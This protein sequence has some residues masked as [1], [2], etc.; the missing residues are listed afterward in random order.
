MAT[1][2]RIDLLG[3][4]RVQCGERGVTRFPTQKTGGLL[5]Y[6][7]YYDR[8][9]HP[10]EAL[11]EQ[12][13][14]EIDLDAA[15]ASLRVALSSLRHLLDPPGAPDGTLLIASRAALSLD[16]S[17]F[18]TDI[19]E[20]EAALQAAARID[21]AVERAGLL[22]RAIDLY[23]GELLPGHRGDW[24]LTER[25]HLAEERLQAL[26]QLGACRKHS[27]CAID[28]QGGTH[29]TPVCISRCR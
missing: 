6:L 27:S 16:P 10:R 29:E 17:A 2:W 28:C 19:A 14:P 8:H 1:A 23:R 3:G 18:T 26:Q 13:W 22:S 9:P 20:F 24:I 12:L 25:Q 21:R 15:R 4:L 11:I 7:A 5:A